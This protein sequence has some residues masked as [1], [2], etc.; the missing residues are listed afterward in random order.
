MVQKQYEAFYTEI[1]KQ[2]LFS[3]YKIDEGNRNSEALKTAET[4]YNETG[5]S[6]ISDAFGENKDEP[7][8]RLIN[9]QTYLFPKHCSFY[10]KNVSQLDEY[11]H[12]KKYDVIV[13]DPPWWNKYI[14]RK[15]AKTPHGYKM[16]Y[17]SDL[18]ELSIKNLLKDDGLVVV[19]CTN[20]QQHL[21]NLLTDIF[22][23]WN[24]TFAAKWY[25][26]KVLIFF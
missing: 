11:L 22:E 20:S 4:I 25:W 17:C 21:E 24:V 19:W 14:R 23:A 12:D 15:K 6:T 2:G 3:S 13:L 7:T 8:L 9:E 1:Q 10:C 18:K 26:M 5:V 16:M